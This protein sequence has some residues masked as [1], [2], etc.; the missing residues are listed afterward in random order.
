MIQTENSS[1][2][3]QL[4]AQL[5]EARARAAQAQA[6]LKKAER[7][8][9]RADGDV[10]D[11]LEEYDRER[12]RMWGDRPDVAALLASDGSGVF[13]QAAEALA[14]A[15]GLGLGMAWSD[16]GQSVLHLQLN[17]GDADAVL[18]AKQ[19]VLFFAPYVRPKRGIVRFSVQHHESGDFAVELRYS[20]KTGGA[21]VRRLHCGMELDTQSFKTLEEALGHIGENHWFEDVIDVGPLPSIRMLAA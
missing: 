10:A 13:R 6:E 19:A 8:A 21:H 18:R 1:K 9:E 20:P 14:G 11:L 7:R 17:R 16:T 4:A 3:A 15:Y 2:L 5:A 12:L